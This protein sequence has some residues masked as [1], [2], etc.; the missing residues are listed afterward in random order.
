MLAS[1]VFHFGLLWEYAG[2]P[3]NGLNEAGH[4]HSKRLAMT[5]QQC[6]GM[7]FIL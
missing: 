7:I 5:A 6:D 2:A 3:K 4:M 1:T